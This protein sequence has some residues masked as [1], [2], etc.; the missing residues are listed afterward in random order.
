MT[1][2]VSYKNGLLFKTLDDNYSL[3]LNLRLQ[4][5]FIYTNLNVSALDD[6]TTSS[7]RF[8]RARLLASGNMMHPWLKYDTQ[9][10]FEGE[11]AALLDAAIE[12]SYYKQMKFKVGQFKVPFNREFLISGIGLQLV[13]RSLANAEFSIQ[14]DIGIQIAGESLWD[15]VEYSLGIFNGSGINKTNVDDDYLYAGRIV[16][17]PVGGG[18]YPYWQAAL[19]KPERLNLAIGFAFAY[20]PDLEVE[21]RE[22]QAGRLGIPAVL[23]ARSDVTQYTTDVALK[24]LDFSLEGGYYYRKIKPKED[25]TYGCQDANGLYA[26]GGYFVVPKKVEIAA[27]YAVVEPDTPST[28]YDNKRSEIT[29]GGTYYFS[30]HQLKFQTN[31]S[32]INR[33]NS[34]GDEE[35]HIF[36]GVL[37]LQF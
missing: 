32:L 34:N 15:A 2:K 27:R 18:S 13:E 5:Y 28:I 3:K 23:S 20:M 14:R 17:T 31:Y 22:T 6:K 29:G 21:E 10:M 36:Y 16:W 11:E 24:Y 37:T 4:P 35:E 30:G 9:I 1:L 12:A 26:Q 33:D 7:I 25:T 19:D 8:R